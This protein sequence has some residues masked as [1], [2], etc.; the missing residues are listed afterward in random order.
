MKRNV[1]RPITSVTLSLF[2]EQ[3]EELRRM[4]NASMFLREEL[5]KIM[6][7]PLTEVQ[8]AALNYLYNK[9]PTN[10]PFNL[11]TMAKDNGISVSTMQCREFLLY[12]VTD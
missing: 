9:I 2:A 5:D 7:K 8:I 1:K 6:S 11:M 4:P 3:V 12:H 10:E